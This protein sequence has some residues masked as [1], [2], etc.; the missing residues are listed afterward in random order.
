MCQSMSD[1]PCHNTLSQHPV[2]QLLPLDEETP[3]SNS[4]AG[5]FVKSLTGFQLMAVTR[6]SGT[7]DAGHYIC[8]ACDAATGQWRT[9]DDSIIRE[10]G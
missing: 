7:A 9:F 2:S 4:Q 8:D 1:T 6:H 5:G 3:A 10:V